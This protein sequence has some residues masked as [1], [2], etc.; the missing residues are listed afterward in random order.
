M[1]ITYENGTSSCSALSA[2]TTVD[3]GAQEM[4]AAYKFLFTADGCGNT[5]NQGEYAWV[6][7]ALD[8]SQTATF[9]DSGGNHTTVTAFQM[10][11]HAASSTRLRGGMTLQN[12]VLQSLDAPP[13]TTQ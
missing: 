6:H 13:A 2:P 4:G 7:F 8:D 1:N 9:P 11:Y 3:L 12:G 5:T 10:F